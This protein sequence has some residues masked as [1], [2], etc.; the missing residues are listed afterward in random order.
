MGGGNENDNP[1]AV[2]CSLLEADGESPYPHSLISSAL[3]AAR[4]LLHCLTSPQHAAWLSPRPL[5]L[6]ANGQPTLAPAITIPDQPTLRR[7]S[8]LLAQTGTA[9]VWALR[10]LVTHRRALPGRRLTTALWAEGA[11]LG[12]QL[13]EVGR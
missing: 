7:A 9:R 6:D 13:V 10:A 8:L 12:R 1:N 3:A 11:A 4:L 5:A 2:A